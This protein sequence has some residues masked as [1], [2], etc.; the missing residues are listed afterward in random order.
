MHLKIEITAPPRPHFAPDQYEYSNPEDVTTSLQL[1]TDNHDLIAASVARFVG[2][3][4]GYEITPPELAEEL[5][6]RLDDAESR[7][8]KR[9]D[10]CRELESE[11][12]QLWKER[13]GLRDLNVARG[14]LIA[15][16]REIMGELQRLLA[17]TGVR[18]PRGLRGR[19]RGFLD[20]AAPGSKPPANSR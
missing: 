1:T 15:E 12:E 6:K 10:S 5:R 14:E 13:A 8:R 3:A 7:A 2:A 9:T 17:G 16:G 11:R 19:L 4:L 20:P 18:W